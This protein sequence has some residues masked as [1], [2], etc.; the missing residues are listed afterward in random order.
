MMD[1]LLSKKHLISILCT[2]SLLL[3]NSI[4]TVFAQGQPPTAT[5]PYQLFLPMINNT[6]VG[7]PDAA[8]DSMGMSQADMADAGQAQMVSASA[9]TGW[10]LPSANAAVTNNAGDNNGFETNPA[11]VYGSNEPNGQLAGDWS[12]G[13]C[14]SFPCADTQRDQHLFTNFGFSIPANSLISGI[15]VRLDAKADRGT[16]VACTTP[17]IGAR[18]SGNGGSTWTAY[19]NTAIT[20]YTWPPSTHYLGTANDLWGSAWS[21]NNFGNAAFQVQ[22]INKA[23]DP[24]CSFYLDDL[25]I[26]VNYTPVATP[27][28]T[29]NNATA[30]E[31]AGVMTF[32]VALSASTSQN[33]TFNYAT[34]NNTAV[35]GSDYTAQSGA[36]TIAAGSTATTISVPLLNDTVAENTETF[37]VNLS[38]VTN[39]VLANGQGIGTI[40]DDDVVGTAPTNLAAAAAHSTAISL[41]W[42]DNASNETGFKIERCLGLNC[43]NFAQVFTTAANTTFWQN[44]GLAPSTIYCYRVFAS[45]SSVTPS[46]SFCARTSSSTKTDPQLSTPPLSVRNYEFGR[47]RTAANVATGLSASCMDLHDR[48]WVLAPDGKAYHT[49]HPAVDTDP[50]TGQTCYM[51]H[52]HGDD[53][54]KSPLLV[55]FGGFPPFGYVIQ[56]QNPAGA[57]DPT[58]QREEDHVGHKVT[59]VPTFQAAFGNPTNLGGPLYPTGIS[60]NFLSKIHQGSH[61]GDAFTNHLHEYFLTVRCTDGT[62]FSVKLLAPIGHPDQVLICDVE[63]EVDVLTQGITWADPLL[64]IKRAVLVQ[65]IGG[66]RREFSC[67]NSFLY[68]KMLATDVLPAGYDPATAPVAQVDLWSQGT[69]VT[70][71][72]TA[73][74]PGGGSLAFGPYYIV[75]NP[76]RVYDPTQNK[77]IYTIDLCYDNNG[78]KKPKAPYCVSAPAQKPAWNSPLSPFNGTLRAVNLKQFVIYNQ[79]GA[80]AFCTNPL[81]V[82]LHAAPCAPQSGEILQQ[83]AAIDNKWQAYRCVSN[84]TTACGQ[85]VESVTWAICRTPADPTQPCY[86]PSDGLGMGPIQDHRSE[87][88]VHAPN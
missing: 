70:T 56:A 38:A 75:K 78:V 60:C 27:Q 50:A 9:V 85:T 19:K 69:T 41:R 58:Q 77:V 14:T 83:V 55:D 16:N 5:A 33:V 81:G 46:N 80:S 74:R 3:Q 61:S 24:N 35:A 87:Q 28:L 17:Q 37:L 1:K 73:A 10:K 26:Q 23:N 13:A 40:L 39:A 51:G 12:S 62:F 48:Y 20:S 76:A 21:S 2:F 86:L 6:I 66:G 88:G 15:Q 84:S 67:Y 29:I 22:L 72:P 53:P 54:S 82:T 31:N 25:Q 7:M 11:N 65:P 63:P 52:E 36:K 32:V 64:S 79:G 71:P 18:L 42:N 68:K 59:V 47:W 43:T 8:T 30:N 4:F 57:L 49:W 45:N 34:A 44:T